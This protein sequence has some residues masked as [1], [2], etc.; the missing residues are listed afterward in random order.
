MAE[1]TP[2]G[3]GGPGRHAHQ[4]SDI[5]AGAVVWFGI[6]LFLVVAA[7][8]IA[9]HFG[10]SLADRRPAPGAADRSPLAE[11]RLPPGPRLQTDP[12]LDMRAWRAHENALLN[13][14]G[15]VDEASG[16]ARIPIEEAKKLLLERG[17]PV[18]GSSEGKP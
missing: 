5:N 7:V 6:A 3:G 9:T 17:L 14:A 11:E 15:W 10:L 13:S 12:P 16:V 1:T 2:S 18:A 4:E 8:A